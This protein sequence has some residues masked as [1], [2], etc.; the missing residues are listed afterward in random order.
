MNITGIIPVYN[1]IDTTQ[2][3]IQSLISQTHVLNEIIVVDDGSTDGTAD[4]LKR[5]ESQIPS[6]RV[7]YQKNKGVASARNCAIRESK[8]E[9]ILTL[10]AD[11][12][13][14]PSFAAK[15]LK[16]FENDEKLGAVMCGYTRVV[17]ERKTLHYTPPTIDLESCLANNG[18]LSCLLFKRQAIMDAGCYDPEFTAGFEDWDLNIRILKKGYSFGVV[19]E[20]LFH[21]TSR[22]NSRST[23]ADQNEVELRLQLFYKYRI[24]YE[25]HLEAVYRKLFEQ[26]VQLRKQNVLLRGKSFYL[27]Q[28]S[29][30][31]LIYKL[32]KLCGLN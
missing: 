16:L 11:D 15:A 29:S 19:P 4:L 17:N 3:A 12:Y 6:L 25:R 26:I 14:E 7:I 1:G 9:Y 5:L 2:R 13:Y 20:V 27:L 10:D 18:A 21:Y 8:S 23:N 30:D 28:E 32:K 22:P 24:D 31:R